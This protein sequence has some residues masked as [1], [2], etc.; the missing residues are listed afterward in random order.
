MLAYK[1]LS[2][3]MKCLLLECPPSPC[4]CCPFLPTAAKAAAGLIVL[5]H[6]TGGRVV[7]LS[8]PNRKRGTGLATSTA[9]VAAAS[10]AIA[11]SATATQPSFDEYL[12][13]VE[14]SG[15]DSGGHNNASD[16]SGY[17]V[18]VQSGN[19]SLTPL[20]G[21]VRCR[22]LDKLAKR[23]SEDNVQSSL[24]ATLRVMIESIVEKCAYLLGLAS[25]A[26][27]TIVFFYGLAD[28][29]RHA[30]QCYPCKG[31]L[32]TRQNPKLLSTWWMCGTSSKFYSRW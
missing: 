27:K 21:H 12:S 4:F 19:P 10:M 16:D 17:C 30:L 24:S 26:D 1:G 3:C 28:D 23:T 25:L 11:A 15:L 29:L 14:S 20:S 2:N 8:L 7:R 31:F 18:V 13:V 22:M 5:G 6:T 9:A 32:Q